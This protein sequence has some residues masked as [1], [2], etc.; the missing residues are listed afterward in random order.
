LAQL[1]DKLTEDAL[2]DVAMVFVPAHTVSSKIALELYIAT[3]DVYG[4]NSDAGELV[5]SAKA[6][7]ELDRLVKNSDE[8]MKK[9]IPEAKNL[10][11]VRTFLIDCHAAFKQASGGSKTPPATGVAGYLGKWVLDKV[12]TEELKDFWN[13]T[14]FPVHNSTLSESSAST[15]FTYLDHGYDGR[16][17]ILPNEELHNKFKYSWSKPKQEIYVY[18][19]QG[20]IKDP[21]ALVKIQ[22]RVEN[23]GTTFEPAGYRDMKYAPFKHTDASL[24]VFLPNEMGIP[25]THVRDDGIFLPWKKQSQSPALITR[26]SSKKWTNG[27]GPKPGVVTTFGDCAGPTASFASDAGSLGSLG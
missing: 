26:T 9:M 15:Q 8:K 3:K 19:S 21:K 5:D 22:G 24:S 11:R 14:Y 27:S 18:A 4:N 20:M 25:L 12:T 10:E 23:A 17:G 13:P 16:G 6:L 7:K 1:Q 2:H